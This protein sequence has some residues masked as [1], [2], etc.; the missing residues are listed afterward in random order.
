V[1]NPLTEGASDANTI[2]ITPADER[3]P[4]VAAARSAALAAV[5]RLFDEEREFLAALVRQQSTRGQ[6]NDVQRLLASTLRTMGLRVEEVPVERERIAGLPGYSPA[7]WSYDHLFQVVGTQPAAGQGGR[8]LVLNGHVDV[9]S[10]TPAAHWTHDPWGAEVVDGRLYGRGACDMKGGV[11]AMVYAL[12]AVQAAGVGLRGDVLVESVIDEECGGNGTLALLAQGYRA[13]AA[14]IPEPSSLGLT[15]AHLGVLWC[16]ID[17]RGRAAHAGS[18]SRAV[19]AVEKACVVLGGIKTLEAEANR[20]TA[21]HPLYAAVAHPLNYNVGVIQ[22]GDWPSSVPEVCTLEVR[23]ACFP[24]EDL[25]AVQ[26]RFCADL[27]R[28][29]AADDWLRE[30]PPAIA[31]FGFRGQGAVYDLDSAIV[32]T[33]A[34]NHAELVGAPPS[35]GVSTASDDRRFFQL[36]YGIPALCYGPA[37][38]QLHAVDEWVDLASVRACTRVLTGVLIDWCGV[39]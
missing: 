13:D 17:V 12:K 11:A 27:L 15:R 24:G 7:D 20:A 1:M 23:F 26:A 6:T 31:F 35:V 38:G 4:R 19:N 10:A 16:R 32:R 5:D 2:Q 37:G 3:E 34:A 18:A 33:V 39:V 8:S 9:V 25:D 22:G 30:Q 14:V 28:L 21:R 29:T 36:Y